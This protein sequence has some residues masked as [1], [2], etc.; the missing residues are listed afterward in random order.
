MFDLFLVVIQDE[1]ACGGP[2]GAATCGL[3][4]VMVAPDVGACCGVS[5]GDKVF[6]KEESIHCAFSEAFQLRVGESVTQPLATMTSNLMMCRFV[7]ADITS[8]WASA[9]SNAVCAIEKV[10]KASNV[11][12]DVQRWTTEEPP[13]FLSGE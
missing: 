3:N 6:C 1:V 8:A 5:Q 10:L 13:L 4:A 7:S 9:Y 12:S 2:L 11:L